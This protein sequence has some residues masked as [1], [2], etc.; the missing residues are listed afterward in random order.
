[1]RNIINKSNLLLHSWKELDP[2]M[3]F[4]GLTLEEFQ[5]MVEPLVEIR[6]SIRKADQ[7]RVAAVIRRD[8][9]EK[10]LAEKYLRI[11]NA[12][13]AAPEHGEDSPL[14]GAIGYVVRSAKQSGLS[15]VKKTEPGTVLAE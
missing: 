2:Q 6:A 12:I 8:A 13:K 5:A 4:A 15:R 14:Y 3:A 11:V 1:M 9:G 10:A 7:D